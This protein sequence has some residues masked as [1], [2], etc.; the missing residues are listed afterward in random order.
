MLYNWHQKSHL[1][2]VH[3]TVAAPDLAPAAILA[4]SD[5]FPAQF[6]FDNVPAYF[7][8]ALLC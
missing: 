6:A 4:C 1:H 2:G 8:R 5:T 3:V 7:H